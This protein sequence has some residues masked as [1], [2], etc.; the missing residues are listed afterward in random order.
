MYTIFKIILLIG[1]IVLLIFE[2]LQI[3]RKEKNKE[4][5]YRIRYFIVLII[6]FGYLLYDYIRDFV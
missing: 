2:L 4:E 6:L 1:A 5:K 3:F